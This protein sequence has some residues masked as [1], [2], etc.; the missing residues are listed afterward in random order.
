MQ[1]EPLTVDEC[2]ELAEALPR[3]CC[4]PTKWIGEGEV[5]DAGGLL[6]RT[7]EHK[8][9]GSSQSELA[10]QNAVKPRCQATSPIAQNGQANF[11]C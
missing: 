6:S 4:Y 11:L 7:R 3:A 2:D 9:V 1:D 10:P 5:A 8:K